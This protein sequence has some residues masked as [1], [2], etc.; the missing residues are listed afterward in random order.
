MTPDLI[1]RVRGGKW[2]P[3]AD[4]GD[5]DQRNAMAARGCSAF[6]AVQKSLGKILKGENPGDARTRT[7]AR[8]TGSCSRR[9]SP[10]AY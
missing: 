2:N 5:R 8:G 1:E 9:A 10:S 3:Q 7:T 4:E 6:S